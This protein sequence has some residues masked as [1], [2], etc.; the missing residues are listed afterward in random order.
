MNTDSADSPYA[1]FPELAALPVSEL[2]RSL[3]RSTMRALEEG[4]DPAALLAEVPG[5]VGKEQYE[6]AQ[7]ILD[8]VAAFRKKPQMSLFQRIF[9]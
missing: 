5:V 6:L 9:P 4:M 1:A 8:A 2:T 7:A 3:R